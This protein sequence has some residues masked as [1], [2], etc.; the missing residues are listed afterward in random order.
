MSGTPLEES[1]RLSAMTERT[2]GAASA[3]LNKATG[4]RGTMCATPDGLRK[5]GT[6]YPA[7]RMRAGSRING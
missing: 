3:I 6:G 7:P 1:G 4:G 5:E 2:H